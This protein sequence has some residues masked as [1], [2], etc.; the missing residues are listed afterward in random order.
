MLM[1]CSETPPVPKPSTYL[2]TEFPEHTYRQYII[3]ELSKVEIAPV[4]L[5]Q[6]A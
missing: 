1:A 2:K 4:S 5:G 3:P 6:V